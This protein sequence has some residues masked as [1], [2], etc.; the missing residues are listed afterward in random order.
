M[1]GVAFAV[2]LVV[3]QVGLFL[4]ILDNASVT[5]DAIDADLWVTSRNTPNVDFAHQFPESHVD[6]VRS[7]DGVARSCIPVATIR[8]RNW[9]GAVSA[10]RRRLA[11]RSKA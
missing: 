6:R 2:S 8:D 10:A 4:G 11:S 5:I 3:F 7:I 1:L 9:D